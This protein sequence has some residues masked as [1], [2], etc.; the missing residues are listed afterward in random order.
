MSNRQWARTHLASGGPGTYFSSGG[1]SLGWAPG[2]AIGMKLARPDDFVI[3][4]CGDGVFNF[5]S[6]VAALWGQQKHNTP[7]L[8]LVFNNSCYSASRVP[9]RGLYPD[10]AAV[11]TGNYMATDIT[12]P[13]DYAVVAQSV[14]AFGGTIRD[15]DEAEPV[16]RRAVEA[17]RNGQSAVVDIVL[18]PTQ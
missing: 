17:V 18:A 2:A 13:P 1:A 16:L 4:L 15:P 14:G 9:L 11:R 12:P 10:G 7:S 5:S 6:P 3:A 8:T